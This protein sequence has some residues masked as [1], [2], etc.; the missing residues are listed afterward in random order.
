M[1]KQIQYIEYGVFSNNGCEVNDNMTIRTLIFENNNN[2]SVKL[3]DNNFCHWIKV[4][5]GG[6]NI[7][8]SFS[9]R[10]MPMKKLVKVYDKVLDFVKND[11]PTLRIETEVVEQ[12]KSYGSHFA[13][14]LKSIK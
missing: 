10:D 8:I 11:K 9:Y 14:L 12:K 6:E 1:R 2:V 13:L 5:S 7:D 4:S 3:D